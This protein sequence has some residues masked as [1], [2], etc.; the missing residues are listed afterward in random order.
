MSIILLVIL[1]AHP[2]YWGSACIR[3]IVMACPDFGI[4]RQ[5]KQLAPRVKEVVGAAAWE[6]TA[7]SA[8][9]CM[10]NGVTT[11]HI[12]W[13][14]SISHVP[15]RMLISDPTSNSVSNMIWGVTGEVDSSSCQLPNIKILVIVEKLIK[16]ILILVYWNIIHS[17]KQLLHLSDPLSDTDW[18]S[19]TLPLS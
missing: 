9:V 14:S 8:N 13:R 6:V 18:R 7:C 16:N 10:E 19:V 1:N 11:K 2:R 5:S 4:V 15:I 3:R 12:I 17:T